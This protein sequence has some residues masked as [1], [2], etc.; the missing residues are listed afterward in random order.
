MRL[1]HLNCGTLR[2]YWPRITSLI[3]C[4]LLETSDGLLLVDTGFGLGDY[5]QPTR[6]VRTFTASMRARV[7]PDET[8][9]RQVTRLGYAPEDVRHIVMTHLHLDHSGGLPDFPHAKVHVHT[10]EH[11]AAMQRSGFLGKFYIPEHWQHGP[12]WVL[13]ETP[14]WGWYG[15]ESIQVVADLSPKV[16]LIPLPGHTP[17]HCAVALETP[18]GWLLHC[19]DATYP[20]FH[21]KQLFNPPPPNWLVRWLLGPHTPRLQALL[22]D[23]GDKVQ[24]I[25]SHDPVGFAKWST[26][27]E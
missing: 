7:D 26:D 6:L 22:S 25:C 16:L 19:G 1:Y 11:Q 12:D 2:P 14:D 5:S 4:L 20:F 3:Y 17:G 27:G 15:F 23:H 13:H 9:V 24:M 18:N 21:E 10:A 8:A